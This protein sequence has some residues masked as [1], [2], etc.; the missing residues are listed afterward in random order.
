LL[1]K[2]DIFASRFMDMKREED[3]NRHLLPRKAGNTEMEKA[4]GWK[5]NDGKNPDTV[6]SA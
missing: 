2:L 5:T 4:V 6:I 1:E 3:W